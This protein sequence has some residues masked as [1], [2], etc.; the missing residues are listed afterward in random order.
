MTVREWYRIQRGELW[1]RDDGLAH[2]VDRIAT[3]IVHDQGPLKWTRVGPFHWVASVESVLERERVLALV[4]A[5]MDNALRRLHQL[6]YAKDL[7]K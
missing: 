2:D 6:F 1:R 3:L 5:D 4:R 7:V